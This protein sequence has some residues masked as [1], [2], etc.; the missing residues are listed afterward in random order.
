MISM[1]KKALFGALLAVLMTGSL[2]QA[3]PRKAVH[4]HSRRASH[5]AASTG[6]STIKKPAGKK[7]G[8]HSRRP[9]RKSGR[10]TPTTKPQ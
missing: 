4:H 7:Y 1:M 3:A 9:S 8:K 5:A 10:H 6:N 2:A